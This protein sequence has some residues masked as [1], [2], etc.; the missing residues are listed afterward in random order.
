MHF[1]HICEWWAVTVLLDKVQ[2][3]MSCTHVQVGSSTNLE[4]WCVILSVAPHHQCLQ[5]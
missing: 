5:N 2:D 1:Y 3:Y 4:L